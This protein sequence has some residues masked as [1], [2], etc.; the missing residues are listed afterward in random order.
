M[1]SGIDT[2]GQG[3]SPFYNESTIIIVITDGGHLTTPNGIQTEL[4]LPMNS[5]VPGA[6]LT[7][8]PFRWDQRIFS[9]VMRLPA[10]VPPD[11][12]AFPFIPSA[13]NTA[14]DVMCEVTGGRSYAVY[15]Q[16]MLN[17]AIESLVQKVQCGVVVNFEK[18][19]PDPPPVSDSIRLDSEVN[20]SAKENLDINRPLQIDDTEDKKMVNHVNQ[21]QTAAWHSCRKLIYV[22]RSAQKGH[23]TGHWPIPEGYWPDITSPSLPPRTAHPVVQFSCQPSEPLVIENLPFDKYELEPSP[24]TLYILERR[25]PNTCWQ[26]FV[27]NSS[28]FSDMCHPFGY[29]KASSSLTSVNLFVMPYNYPVLLPLLDELFK[30]H[31]L[32]PNQQ[33]RQRFENYLKTMPGYYAPNLRRALARMGAPNLV[34]DNMDNCLSYSV[35]TYLKKLKNQARIEMDRLNAS[36]GQKPPR[37]EGIRVNTRSKTS[38]LQRKDFNQLL[39]NLGGNIAGLKQELQQDYTG[40]TLAVEDLDIKPQ[41]YRNPYD[42]PRKSIIDQISRM[43]NNFLRTSI[44]SESLIDLDERH[45]VPISQMGNYQEVLKKQPPALRELE[46][47][48]TRLHMFGNPFKVNKQL[49]VDEAE[50]AIVIGNSPRKRAASESPPNSPHRKRKPGPLPRDIPYRRPSSSSITPPASPAPSSVSDSEF[51]SDD[52]PLQIITD[53][54]DESASLGSD[55]EKTSSVFNHVNS[56]QINSVNSHNENGISDRGMINSAVEDRLAESLSDGF[57]GS[58][59]EQ[60][61]WNFN[62]HLKTLITKEVKKPGRNFEKLFQQLSTIQGVYQGLVDSDSLVNEMVTLLKYILIQVKLK[63]I[64]LIIQPELLQN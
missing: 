36:I 64:H 53:S 24:L 6:E 27:S 63:V 62:R 18:F 26:V 17:A 30:V 29:L 5:V 9:L 51:E 23:C 10:S 49:T 21:Q 52:T 15:S 58:K 14:I 34:S 4:N 40:F 56:S 44:N 47:T 59:K 43:R 3:R 12:S 38:I 7:K 20:G 41:F 13:E 42:I 48:P 39:A 60:Q 8:E 1:T 28:K 61:A 46:S 19:G 54:D 11:V 55:G 16:K 25:Q 37:H 32:K 33:W 22:P 2:Y 31:N 35:I 50:E 45:R 57:I